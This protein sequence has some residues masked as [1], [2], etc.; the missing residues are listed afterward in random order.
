MAGTTL[1]EIVSRG[2]WDKSKVDSVKL[3]E[4]Y[5]DFAD[6]FDKDKTNRLPEHFQHNLAIEIEK[7]KQLF[8]DLFMTSLWPN[9][10]YFVT[11]WMSY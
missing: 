2:F 9:L 11:T 1:V 3:L 4:K 6:V 7:K 8:L 10:E 5:S